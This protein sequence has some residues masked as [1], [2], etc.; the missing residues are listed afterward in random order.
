MEKSRPDRMFSI[1]ILWSSFIALKDSLLF[2]NVFISRNLT[3]LYYAFCVFMNLLYCWFIS[4]LGFKS[5][6][7][8]KPAIAIC[9]VL[10]DNVRGS[11]RNDI[12]FWNDYLGL[13]M[14]NVYWTK[15]PGKPSLSNSN[16][17]LGMWLI[18][19]RFSVTI[20][21]RGVFHSF[22]IKKNV[23]ETLTLHSVSLLNWA[24]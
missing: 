22:D 17:S 16:T 1:L 20:L 4:V 3:V 23:Y 5:V 19:S 7:T 12:R 2:W 8:S 14:R 9:H 11:C 18:W 21:S 6:S 10:M 13:N 24:Q 15:S